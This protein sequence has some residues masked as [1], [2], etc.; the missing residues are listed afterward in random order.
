MTNISAMRALA[1]LNKLE[2]L[3]NSETQAKPANNKFSFSLFGFGFTGN[4][5]EVEDIP[6]EDKS[7]NKK[8]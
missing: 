4:A 3:R 2:E 5:Q 7:F 6:P 1:E 8:I